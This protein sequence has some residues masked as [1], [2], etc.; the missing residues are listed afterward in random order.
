MAL[1]KLLQVGPVVRDDPIPS[2]SEERPVEPPRRPLPIRAIVKAQTLARGWLARRRVK[3]EFEGFLTRFFVEGGFVGRRARVTVWKTLVERT[4]RRR[5][6]KHIVAKHHGVVANEEIQQEGD[7][8]VFKEQ[9]MAYQVEVE[10]V[11]VP[12]N[13]QSKIVL[14]IPPK[15]ILIT[16]LRRAL[17]LEWRGTYEYPIEKWG[18]LKR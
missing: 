12:Q 16:A 8:E 2:E 18:L 3:R 17:E 10:N 11:Y 7:V 9:V 6:V 14:T 13:R 5:K 4:R 1:T 15:S